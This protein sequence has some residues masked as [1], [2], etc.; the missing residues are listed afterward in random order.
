MIEVG[1]NNTKQ[2]VVMASAVSERAT[3]TSCESLTLPQPE[4]SNT[5]KEEIEVGQGY[6][7]TLSPSIESP[8]TC[9]H[10]N[11]LT[12]K[13]GTMWN[14]K[15]AITQ[16]NSECDHELDGIAN[17]T[18]DFQNIPAAQLESTVRLMILLLLN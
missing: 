12:Q 16:V 2:T 1:S 5:F 9:I 3:S 6:Q 17:V 18:S 14:D 10:Y 4:L 15:V 13:P 8:V 11:E 7:R